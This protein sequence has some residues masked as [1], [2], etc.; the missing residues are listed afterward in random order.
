MRPLK[1]LTWTDTTSWSS[2]STGALAPLAGIVGESQSPEQDWLAGTSRSYRIH[3]RL[4]ADGLIRPSASSA[5]VEATVA[6]TVPAN[7]KWLVE[8]VEEDIRVVE[9]RRSNGL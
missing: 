3:Q 5:R 8:D 6:P 7:A 2:G 9:K 4:H 1:G